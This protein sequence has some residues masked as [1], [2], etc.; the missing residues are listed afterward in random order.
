MV[1]L[2]NVTMSSVVQNGLIQR[3]RIFTVSVLLPDRPGELRN[4]AD[5][6]AEDKGNIIK[7]YHNQFISTNRA[8]AVELRITIEAFGTEHKTQ[9]IQGLRNRGYDPRVIVTEL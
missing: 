4:V 3:D 8:N 5:A 6:V 9:I 1:K 7:L 2:D